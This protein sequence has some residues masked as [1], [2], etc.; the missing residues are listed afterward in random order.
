MMKYLGL[1]FL[2][3]VTPAHA[4]AVKVLGPGVMSCKEALR[5]AWWIE[6]KPITPLAAYILGFASAS[7]NDDI[8]ELLPPGKTNKDL[9]GL[10]FKECTKNP[11]DNLFHVLGKTID[12]LKAAQLHNPEMPNK[13]K[14]F[15][16]KQKPEEDY[17]NRPLKPGEERF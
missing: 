1:A 6:D 14:D 12:G 2:L 9:V 3:T 15:S 13:G 5:A 16:K 4:G 10:V 17:S 11:S 8:P 7:L